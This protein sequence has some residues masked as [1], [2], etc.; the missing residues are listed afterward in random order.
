MR[1]HSWLVYTL[2]IASCHE[3]ADSRLARAVVDSLPGGIPRVIS[4]G[5]TAWTDSAGARLVEEGRFSGED[6]TPGELGEP[7]V[8]AVDGEGRV[9]VV[10]SKPAIIK[11]FSPDGA[12][13]RTIG[14][15]G[16]GPGEF[17]AGF[18]AVRGATV[19]LQDPQIGRA[20]VWDTAGAF[21]RSW[22]TSCCFWMDIQLDRQNLLYVPSVVAG[23]EPGRG[24]PYVRW[25]LDGVAID[26]LSLPSQE[27]GKFWTISLK[28]A[29]GKVAMAMNI[30]VP[31]RPALVSALHPDGG[32]ING[33]T[34]A[35]SLTRSNRGT[36]TV[37][38]FGRTWTPEPITDERR[39]AE[40]ES[41]MKAA[42]KD[43]GGENLRATFRLED[44]PATLPALAGIG[45]DESGRVWIR[46]HA[47]TVADSAHTAFEVFD[48]A[49]A[50]LGPVRV[51][52][53][54]PDFGPR[55]W[56]RDGIV[57]IVEDVDGRPTVVRLRLTAA[58]REPRA[59]RAP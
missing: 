29:D 55:A 32:F 11:V 57:V 20:S 7:Q 9:Y 45:V 22:T 25:S 41:R 43:F 27:P 23:G 28:G 38:V 14:R 3:A 52:F 18:I 54:L 4:D 15:E 53:K 35:Y 44:V 46:R 13:V 58:S 17:R 6:G 19:V 49:G 8:L 1:T 33:R 40:V 24:V 31:L 59:G 16:E 48:S 47:L 26:T 2:I 10:D 42:A 34:D 21:L 37:R 30:P 12:L 39:K 51:P 56:T 5:P 50:F 36:D